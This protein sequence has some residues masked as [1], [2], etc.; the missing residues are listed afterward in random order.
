MLKKQAKK[1]WNACMHIKII[2]YTP[3][4][5]VSPD[6]TKTGNYKVVLIRF[7]IQIPMNF[8]TSNFYWKT[9]YTPKAWTR[10]NFK[11]LHTYTYNSTSPPRPVYGTR[12]FSRGISLVWIVFFFSLT[13]CLPIAKERIIEILLFLRLLALCKMQ[14][15][16]F[17]D[18]T[19]V[20]CIRFL[21]R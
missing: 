5:F 10:G 4:I 16:S 18:W 2:D 1:N 14:T 13:G 11:T 20:N 12:Q 21:W 6:K 7:L 8:R 3:T 17:R 19:R 15:A 9:N